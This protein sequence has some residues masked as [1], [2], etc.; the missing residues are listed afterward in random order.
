MSMFFPKRLSE[1]AAIVA[2]I[3]DRVY[4]E[5]IPPSTK[6]FDPYPCILFSYQG[7]GDTLTLN[8]R[9]VMSRPLYL[10]QLVMKSSALSATEKI[11][12]K[13]MDD[14][15]QGS[16]NYLH[17]DIPGFYFN[18]WRERPNPR[19]SVDTNVGTFKY[20]GGLYRLEVIPTA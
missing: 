6:T 18:A 1:G 12:L 8:A 9:R 5:N 7:G 4:E 19:S 10:V 13:E 14:L 2:L 3:A 16:R 17:E 20:R 11:A 15:L